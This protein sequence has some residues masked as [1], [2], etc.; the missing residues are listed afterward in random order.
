MVRELDLAIRVVCPIFGVSVGKYDDKSTWTIHFKPEASA[1]HRSVAQSVLDVFEPDKPPQPVAPMTPTGSGR[2]VPFSPGGDYG[3]PT[4]PFPAVR[5]Y[6][7][8]GNTITI[9][10]AQHS[11][12]FPGI[13]LLYDN[14]IIDGV[15]GQIVAPNTTYYVYAFTYFGSPVPSIRLQLSTTGW[16]TDEGSVVGDIGNGVAIKLLDPSQ[17]IVGMLRTELNGRWRGDDKRQNTS[18]FYNR[19][20]IGVRCAITDCFTQSTEW[21][22]PNSNNRISFVCWQDDLPEVTL[23]GTMTNDTAGGHME[24]A[25]AV[26]G[27]IGSSRAVWDAPSANASTPFSIKVPS[28]G[29]MVEGYHEYSVWMKTDGS[30]GALRAGNAGYDGSTQLC[31]SPVPS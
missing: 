14:C 22:E 27:V 26:D 15:P 12:P 29:G 13:D 28:D 16:R 17:S 6:P 5:Y 1:F 25:I 7:F 23:S 2:F 10:G 31:A 8:N 3:P 18:S 21:T 24:V 20:R 11:I 19:V 4:S 30:T 9:A